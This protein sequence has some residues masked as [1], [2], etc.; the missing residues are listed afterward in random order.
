MLTQVLHDA[1]RS[2]VHSARWQ[3]SGPCRCARRQHPQVLN[4]LSVIAF[5]TLPL[6][7]LL[8][9]TL[10]FLRSFARP[11]QALVSNQAGC[12]VGPGPCCPARRNRML[13]SSL[14]QALALLQTPGTQLLSLPRL[15]A[16]LA[17][18]LCWMCLPRYKGKPRPSR[19]LARRSR[20]TSS[21][22]I[23]VTA[24]TSR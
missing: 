11:A 6:L 12:L 18:A 10:A 21:C 1:G 4:V 9:L 19:T 17:L 13:P 15:P 22:S 16:C 5:D 20:A 14:P 24:W 3:P 2:H 23:A 7:L 8:T